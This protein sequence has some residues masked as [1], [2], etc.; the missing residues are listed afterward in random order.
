MKIVEANIK[1]RYQETDQM[2]VVYHGNYLVWFEIG[3]TEFLEAL[4]FKYAEMEKEG[5]V[6]PV[7]DANLQFKSPIRYGDDVVIKTWV[8]QYDG[9][10]VVYAYEIVD[11]EGKT[12]VTGTTSHVCVKKDSF[13]PVST[14]KKFPELHQAYIQAKGDL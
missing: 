11:G 7:V 9:L 13:R 6:S 1:V 12:A 3:R 2:G 5:I 14:R 4:G 8:D 10:K